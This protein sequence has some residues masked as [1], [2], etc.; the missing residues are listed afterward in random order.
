MFR[1]CK[2]LKV[3]WFNNNKITNREVDIANKERDIAI[4]KE[5]E[6][7]KE[8]DIAIKKENEAI[9]ERDEAL[10]QLK[11]LQIKYEGL[12]IQKK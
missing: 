4:K 7:N 2:D 3:F 12:I 8:R 10:E 1:F 5:N 9:K 11:A 6:A